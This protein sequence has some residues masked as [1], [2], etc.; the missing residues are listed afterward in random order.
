MIIRLVTGVIPKK[1][2]KNLLTIEWTINDIPT[3]LTIGIH[4]SKCM[5]P[6]TIPAIE[7]IAPNKFIKTTIGLFI[8]GVYPRDN[9]RLTL[10]SIILIILD[11]KSVK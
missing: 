6:Q 8:L 2:A 11:S 3:K 10:A 1:N 5:N 7:A 9:I 4:Q